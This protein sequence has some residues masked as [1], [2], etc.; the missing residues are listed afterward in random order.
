VEGAKTLSTLLRLAERAAKGEPLKENIDPQS[1]QQQSPTECDES[2]RD[3]MAE[4]LRNRPL[5][6]SSAPLH[7]WATFTRKAAVPGPAASTTVPPPQEA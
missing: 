4:N 2:S 5:D 6:A 7:F 1:Q 3:G